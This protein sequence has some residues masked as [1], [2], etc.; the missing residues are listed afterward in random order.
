M[1]R[2]EA[3]TSPLGRI[4]R[5]FSWSLAGVA[6]SQGSAL[7]AALLVARILG[8]EEFGQFAAVQSSLVA[9]FNT[10]NLGLGITATRYAAT[11]RGRQPDRLG[12]VLGLCSLASLASGLIS[13]GLLWAC[14]GWTARAVFGSAEL[15]WAFRLAAPYA[16]FMTMN[17][18]Q[19]GT[20]L[21]LE[22]F[23]RLWGQQAVQGAL[24]LAG[25][26]GLAAWLGLE[27]AALSLSLAAAGTWLYTSRALRRECRNER[28][29]IQY[30]GC[31][32]ERSVLGRFLIP[33]TV[34][35]GLGNA[36]IWGGSALVA[37]GPGGFGELALFS[38][39]N[40]LRNL[41]LLGPGLVNRAAG[42]V[43]T[44]MAATAD[45]SYRRTLWRNVAANSLGALACAGL[46]AAAGPVALGLFGREYGG[47]GKLL[48]VLALAAAVEV[49][50]SSAYQ[51]L[52]SQGRF[53]RQVLTV[54]VWTA[55]L[56]GLAAVWTPGWGAAG[57]AWAYLAAWTV[58]AGLYTGFAWSLTAA[59]EAAGSNPCR[60][61][62]SAS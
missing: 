48:A 37:R 21:G 16:L 9:V 20:L 43:L 31:W 12:R 8:R 62:V 18:Y 3:G 45:G 32:Q 46:L 38:A 25:G 44:S 17:S 61:P 24:G 2:P 6:V 26:A 42:P 5:G 47:G 59:P 23:P 57:L 19:I 55:C 40:T 36:G 15:A 11:W 35:A 56:L 54:A 52:F 49:Y 41:V 53:G 30:R 51:A 4:L 10:G 34:S 50:A 58:S 13:V 60:I 22:A 1:G 7:L 28:I 27:G 33:A 29:R 14:A 39:A